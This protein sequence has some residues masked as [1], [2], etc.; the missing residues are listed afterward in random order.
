MCSIDV[1]YVLTKA[2][3]KNI[4]LKEE[5]NYDSYNTKQKDEMKKNE[6]M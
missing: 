4:A 3:S 6:I 2:L 1:E 5:M